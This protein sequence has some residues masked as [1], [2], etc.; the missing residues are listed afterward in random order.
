MTTGDTVNSMRSIAPPSNS[1]PTS[2]ERRAAA[3]SDGEM[4]ELAAFPL[5]TEN[6]YQQLLYAQLERQGF[7]VIGDLDF[8]LRSLWRARGRV[9]VL[10]FHWP[11]NYYSWWRRPARL[12]AALSWM[13]LPL[14]AVRLAFVRM[15]GYRVVW[16]VH[17]VAPHERRGRF[18]DSVGSK[19]LGRASHILIAHDH[20]TA[21][22]V[23]SALGI[24][25][26]RVE[27]IPHGSYIDVY[28]PGRSREV[29][30]AELGIPERAFVFLSFGHLRAYKEVDVLLEGFASA[31]LANAALVVAGLPLD[32][33]SAADV[34][35]AAARDPRIKPLLE[36]IPNDRVTEL[37]DACDATVL[38][39]GDGGTSGALILALSMGS[40]VIAAANHD[41]EELIGDAGWVFAAG[42]ARSLAAAFE[43]SAQDAESARAKADS[44]YSRAQALN[45]PEIAARTATVIEGG[46]R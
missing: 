11:Q 39:R 37:F 32:A 20:G 4:I 1:A 2:S 33:T 43:E 40:P 17:E 38:T 24:P 34:R 30:R 14:F 22:R 13:K 42:D 19:I 25:A 31:N 35:D 44:A 7:H 45:W 28:P 23:E 41:Y 21:A 3:R 9:R 8:K 27:V 46:R 12:R 5:I 10:H 26:S 16:T 6:P 15:L 36:F 29:V 18:V